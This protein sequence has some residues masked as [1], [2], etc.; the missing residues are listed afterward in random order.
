MRNLFRTVTKSTI[1]FCSTMTNA[2]SL[3]PKPKCQDCCHTLETNTRL[4]HINQAIH[5]STEHIVKE[6][7]TTN[8]ILEHMC[9]VIPLVQIIS[10]TFIVLKAN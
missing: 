7:K 1:R 9:V 3:T 5:D 2:R 6:M 10:A 4:K 8:E